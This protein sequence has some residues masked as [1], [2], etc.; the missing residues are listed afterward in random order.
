MR[1]RHIISVCLVLLLFFPFVALAQS[2]LYYQYWIDDNKDEAVSGTIIDSGDGAGINFELDMSS[3]SPGVHFFTIRS[4]EE[5]VISSDVI[6]GAPQRYI[7]S[8]PA[9][10]SNESS[11][12]LMTYQYWIDDDI[13][14]AVS[15]TVN[16]EEY[17][18]PA[19]LDVSSLSAGVHFY[20]VRVQDAYGKWSAP[21][22]YIFSIPASA[23]D[24]SSA[25][26]MTYQ[27]WIDDDIANAVSVTISGEEYGEP[28]ELDVSS[29]SAGVHFYNVRAQDAYGNWS[30][31]QRYIFSIPAAASDE[32][33]ADLMTY[34]YWI[35]DDIAN[36]VS[37]T[38]SGE[39][40]GEPAELDV[41]GLSAGVHFYNVRV[42]DAYGKWSA[43]QRYIF[44][45]PAAQ[46]QTVGK[47]ITG[48]MYAFNDDALQSVTFASPVDEFDQSLE[49]SAPSPETLTVVDDS[50]KFEFNAT[51]STVMIRRNTPM[52]FTL[53]FRD[54]SGA[55]SAPIVEDFVVTD[56]LTDSV[57]VVTSP[58]TYAVESHAEGGL[59][60][61]RFDVAES[62]KLTLKSSS[63]CGVRLYDSAG[64]LIEAYDSVA[65]KAGVSRTFEA[66]TYYATVFEN[67]EAIE[68]ALS[69]GDE[70][71]MV[72]LR[73]TISYN[74]DT[75]IVTIS[76][77]VDG[78]TYYYTT[79]GDEPTLESTVYT[80]PF[81]VTNNVTIKAIA[82]W[83]N[84]VV[85]AA[86]SYVISTN[87]VATPQISNHGDSIFISCD[88]DGAAIYYTIDGTTP[89]EA[90][91]LYTDTFVVRNNCTIKAIAFKTNLN[92]SEVDSLVVGWIKGDVNDNGTI[93]LDDAVAI[94]N[95]IVGNPGTIFIEEMADING[96]NEIDIFDVIQ[97]V[98]VVLSYEDNNEPSGSR[99]MSRGRDEEQIDL[100]VD[101][102]SI[103]IG[104]DRPER[105]T[106]FRFDISLPDG[107][108][109][110]DVQLSGASGHQVM[111]VNRGGGK[112]RVVGL[113]LSNELLS[114]LGGSFVDMKLSKAIDGEITV[115]N[116][117]F[118]TPDEEMLK[119]AGA[120]RGTTS[121]GVVD[122]DDRQSGN[123][124]DLRGQKQDRSQ[125]QLGKGVY[126]INH[127][128]VIIK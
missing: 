33:S 126:I 75:Q 60:T 34:Q 48:Y 91:T 82:A 39:E 115:G 85:S 40:Y 83:G 43:P 66:G 99:R 127:K 57:N 18:E 45:I 38:I 28:A 110:N 108:C 78:A 117:Y 26:L 119:F 25:D 79:N 89:T 13:A 76:G 11:A 17:G 30:A 24:E 58:G 7:F 23:S 112:Y 72:A 1:N 52:T 32:S 105:F 125:Q 35:D 54:M 71:G 84:M 96:D 128:K 21:Q 67:T 37:V 10:A 68:L 42:Q 116:V 5:S 73:P 124:Y 41:S 100:T 19:E 51:D 87:Q 29:L 16:G 53:V 104:I 77:D 62:A 8:I 81:M 59:S 114:T 12:D 36:A 120:S 63:D 15:V 123:I 46:Q 64:E 3:L 94:I 56:S 111:F 102:N 65:I 97:L 74:E 106:A 121:I 47:Q 61:F 122:A 93:D 9:A 2:S 98:N 49:F 80:D 118:V 69:P 44:S 92:T 88:T 50:C 55:L 20:N 27:Y 4:Y 113:S 95:Y 103:K 22:R 31:P 107:V 109:L 86:R 90:S 6:W 14:N 101:G 70:A